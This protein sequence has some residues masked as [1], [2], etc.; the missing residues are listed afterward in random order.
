MTHDQSHRTYRAYL[1]AD[2]SDSFSKWLGIE[3]PA[4]DTRRNRDLKTGAMRTEFQMRGRKACGTWWPTK[5]Q[6]KASYK[7]ELRMVLL[8]ERGHGWT[9]A[10]KATAVGEY[11][12]APNE[13]CSDQVGE[14]TWSTVV[15]TTT[16]SK[17]RYAAYREFRRDQFEGSLHE[18]QVKR[19][20]ELDGEEPEDPNA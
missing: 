15:W 19:C 14:R 10:F 18:I 9:R 1:H 13:Q 2:G 7:H 12:E 3:K 16:A 17:A 20:P 5:K 4:F 11:V 6:A 8:R